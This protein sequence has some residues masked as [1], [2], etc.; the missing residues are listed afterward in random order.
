MK[1][2]DADWV[3][4]GVAVIAVLLIAA[5]IGQKIYRLSLPTDGWAFTTGEIGSPDQDRPIYTENLLGRPSP[6]QP[7]DRLLAVEGQSFEDILARA[8]RFQLQHP[9]NGQAGSTVQ[10][11][12]ERNQRPVV[13]DVPLYN[14]DLG[15]VLRGFFGVPD[16]PAALPLAG[17][18]WF[19]FLRRPRESAA[20]PLLLFSISLLVV[21]ISNAVVGVGL[22]EMLTPG[23]L[24]VAGF[25]SGWI[26]AA[27]MFPSLLLL[28]LTFP[29]SKRFVVRWPAPVVAL[30][31]GIT[32]TLLVLLGPIAT[33]GWVVTLTMALL[34]LAALVHSLFA[35]R[36]TVGRAQMRW[37]VSGLVV[38]IV[39]F[40]PMNL[41]G[42][43]L[44][45]SWQPPPWLEAIWFPGLLLVAALGFAVAI[46]RYHL[47]DIDLIINRVLVYGSLTSCVVAIYVLVVGYFGTLLDIRGGFV[48]S[49]VVTGIVAV[50]FQPLRGR[51]QRAVNRL[52]YGEREE[53]YRVLARL[54]QRLESA[55]DPAATL[56]TLV[57]TVAESLKLP[58]VAISLRWRDTDE[59]LVAIGAPTTEPMWFPLTY[60]GELVGQ[61]LVSPRRGEATLA[62]ADR[63]L[64]ADLARQAGV[65]VHA[66]RLTGDL[67]RSNE[68]LRAAREHLVSAREEERR[69]LRRDLHDGLGPALASASLKVGAIRRL[70]DRDR[71]AAD[72]LLLDLGRDIG[73]TTDDIRRLVYALRPPALDELGLIGAIRERVTQDHTTAADDGGLRVEVDTPESLPPLPAAIE[74]A[75]Y[76]IAQEALTNV[77]RHAHARNASIRLALEADALC[78]E[79]VDDGVGI[80]PERK[81]GVG[82]RAMRERAEEVGGTFAAEAVHGGGTRIIAR[83]PVAK[84]D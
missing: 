73:A 66:V 41:G 36:D 76:R 4:R 27:V 9:E 34:S 78:L 74:V 72:A 55:F 65:A 39:G 57:Q 43:G 26:Y 70:L 56:P 11:T 75:A 10:Y 58:Y 83:L 50:L 20:R 37:A 23:L 64:L 13:L 79:I 68:D 35:I 59:D 81:G 61:L 24:P 22:P 21:N 29:R 60:Q 31:Y 7:G 84:E 30:P 46:L 15:A 17:V 14:W 12:V 25:F 48:P 51:L 80:S 67:Q 18:G 69:R 1:R 33:I 32:P 54:G 42:L 3:A 2:V 6:L 77:L 19:V 16:V 40:V 53:P 49:L 45:G 71:G 63:R 38:L 82:L 47:F 8:N 5:S 52:M 62:E 28:T 44:L